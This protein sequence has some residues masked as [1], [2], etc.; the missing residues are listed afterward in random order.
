MKFIL[1]ELETERLI[2]KKGTGEDYLWLCG[3]EL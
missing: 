3:R 1:P 2:L